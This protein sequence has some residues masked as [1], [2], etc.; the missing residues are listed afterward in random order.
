MDEFREAWELLRRL[1]GTYTKEAGSRLARLF[2]V[3]GAELAEIRTALLTTE[4]YRDID[5]ATGR[6]LDWIGENVGQARGSA[7][8]RAYRCLI[9]IRIARRFSLGDVDS[10]KRILSFVLRI[11]PTAIEVEYLWQRD[12]EP[13]ALEI[14]VPIE[15]LSPYRMTPAALADMVPELVAAGVRVD[16][17]YLASDALIILRGS[18]IT[19]RGLYDWTAQLYCGPVRDVI[20]RGTARRARL[21]LVGQPRTGRWPYPRAPVA[22]G[23]VPDHHVRGA[24]ARRS[25]VLQ[26]TALTGAS[27][28][29]RCGPL[30]ASGTVGTS[31]PRVAVL[32]AARPTGAG[33]WRRS[34][35]FHC[36][37]EAA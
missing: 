4:A 35:T 24:L 2:R 6:T 11:S 37:E 28:W 7:E 13:A 23:T 19:G 25:V 22:C 10:I 1:P 15:A 21:L 12:G 14:V 30:W 31:A 3:V 9:K 26:A 32:R 33:I 18:P 8:D 34:G 16:T 17:I 20:S 5:Q 36:G 27:L 29:P